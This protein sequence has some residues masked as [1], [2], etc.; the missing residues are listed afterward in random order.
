MAKKIKKKAGKLKAK[1]T[2][3]MTK[4]A[5]LRAASPAIRRAAE[6]TLETMGFAV[7]YKDG[8]IVKLYKSGKIEKLKKIKRLN[9][10]AKLVLD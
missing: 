9:P 10:P 7:I 8:W 5:L 2:A 4:R 1:N 6:R 3:Y